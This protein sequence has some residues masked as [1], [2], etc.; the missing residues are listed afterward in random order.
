MSA[1]AINL[2]KFEKWINKIP[3]GINQTMF[4]QSLLNETI[5]A[6]KT[7]IMLIPLHPS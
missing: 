7:I 1:K 5:K 4:R 2:S 3:A 6:M